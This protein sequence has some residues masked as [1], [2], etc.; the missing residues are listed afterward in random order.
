M[1]DQSEIR[2]IDD[3]TLR[4]N[5]DGTVELKIDDFF[6]QLDELEPETKGRFSSAVRE[7]II[8]HWVNFINTRGLA[9][10]RSLS[11]SSAFESYRSEIH[12]LNRSRDTGSRPFEFRE[13][14]GERLRF[15]HPNGEV[16]IQIDNSYL[17]FGEVPTD[18][19][20]EI[21]QRVFL[22]AENYI[23]AWRP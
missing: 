15:H 3:Q 22:A 2:K 13:I 21:N 7:A 14:A 6:F 1:S 8:G 12:A 4:F 10:R 17:P 18:R 16:A 20:R 19:L 11:S 5:P 23:R 9:A